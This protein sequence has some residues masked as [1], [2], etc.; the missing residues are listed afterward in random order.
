MLQVTDHCSE[1]CFLAQKNYCRTS[2]LGQLAAAPDWL[3]YFRL[4][5]IFTT[6]FRIETEV[7]YNVNL[8]TLFVLMIVVFCF[9][10]IGEAGEKRV[11]NLLQN[12]R[13]ALRKT[14]DL[15]EK[16]RS[17]LCWN[18]DRWGDV[19]SLSASSNASP[20]FKSSGNLVSIEPG[21]RLWQFATLPE[22]GLVKGDTVSLGVKGYQGTGGA[23]QSRLC[24]MLIESAD[25]SWSPK[26]FGLSDKR[27]FFRHGRGELIRS[28][29]LETSSQKV[30]EE[31]VLEQ[32][33][34]KIDPRFEHQRESSADFRNVV[35]V[36]VEF[37]NV[38][39][40]PVWIH[41]PTLVKGKQVVADNGSSRGLPD[42]YRRIPRTM[43]KLSSGKP[44]SILTLGSSIDRG[45][46]NPRLYFYEE[47]PKSP[48]YKEP[49][50]S[51]RPSRAETL[52]TFLADREGRPDLQN[53]VGWSQH[54]FMYTGRMRR[55]LLRKFNYP[56]ENMLLNV[57]ACD[58]SSIGES[59][60]GFREYA[61]LELPPS[62]N[63]NGHPE[64]KSWKELY[65]KLFRDGKAS[66]PDLVIFGHGHNEHI[67]RPDEIAAYE[68]AIRWF[69]RH[70]PDV[71][72]VS[73]MWIRDKGSATSMSEPMQKLCA[74]YGIPFLDV[75]QLLIDLNPTC[76]RYA[77]A[78]DGGHPGAASHYLWYKQLERVFEI[79]E[80]AVVGI[81][82]QHLPARMNDYSYGWEG[83]VTRFQSPDPRFADQRMMIIEDCAF[84]IWSD[85]NK[86][87]T[88]LLIDGK[89]AKDAGHG[90]HSWSKPNPRN[91][92]FVHGRLSLGDRHIIEIPNEK[93]KLV[94]VDNKVCPNRRF[95][96]VDA[97]QW[98]R[99]AEVKSFA[100]EWGA[101]YG[102]KA[103]LLAAGE[104]IEIEVEGTDLSI[105]WLDR[106][107]GGTL[108]TEV[109]GKAAWS[110]PTN[111]AF[112][113]S[114]GRKHFI[115]NRRGVRGLSFYKH[116]VRIRAKDKDVWVLGLFAYD[117]R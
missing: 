105:A 92:T 56:V 16:G 74:H 58:G 3:I 89:P 77:M 7:R 97:K 78:P 79:P 42:F 81:P 25:G 34:L 57:M 37:A 35:G 102:E 117:A 87:M 1:S 18:T 90:R 43:E 6:L 83:D 27:T 14:F 17:V 98:K 106:A 12:P 21:K 86:E 10:S 60:S 111:V 115:E 76:N 63:P 13:F 54:Y 73:C 32:S 30:G 67:D 75:G 96:G 104:S 9:L 29:Q 46:A 68:G 45:S 4:C 101:P 49:L 19:R 65:P 80:N 109:N 8:K 31:F 103:F 51:A 116:H 33:G 50:T 108:V 82:Q 110:Q 24:L 48:K 15:A 114:K 84:N 94:V 91:S 52:K 53:Y 64:G 28:P 61:A 113:D 95:F 112:T 59:H 5:Q 99:T 47:D 26:E 70:Y 93:A 20:N 23:L 36:L 72:F 39:D 22:L 66:E 44:L 2:L 69:Q 88:K 41:S 85:N 107:E 11:D 71:E 100:S 55:E 62:P 40:K 38:S